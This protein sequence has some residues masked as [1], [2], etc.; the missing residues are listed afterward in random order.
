[1]TDER[2][3]LTPQDRQHPPEQRAI[4]IALGHLPGAPVVDAMGSFSRRP[5]E[6]CTA[7]SHRKVYRDYFMR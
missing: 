3:C 4:L 5:G 2:K 1:M 6:R 7:A